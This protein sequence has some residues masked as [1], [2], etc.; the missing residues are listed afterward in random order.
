M[1]QD[2]STA[3]KGAR[4]GKSTGAKGEIKT[5]EHADG[6]RVGVRN[7]S[8]KDGSGRPTIQIN[9]PATKIVT[10]VRYEEH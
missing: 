10:K 1:Q 7:F 5:A 8:G 4:I 9:D 2:A 6:T 3:M